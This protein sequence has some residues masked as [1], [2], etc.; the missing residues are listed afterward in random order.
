[1]STHFD[2]RP[3]LSGEYGE[4][5]L[6]G[7]KVTLQMAV[8]TWVLAM[9]LALILVS[10]RLSGN[11]YGRR[12]V[13]VYVAYHRNVPTLVQFLLWYFAIPSLLPD[14][15]Q[16]WLADFGYEFVFAVIA[17][18]LCEAAFFS[19][20]L[21]SGLR[22]VPDGQMEASRS[23]G[24]GYIRSVRYIVMPQ[25][26]RNCLPSLVNHSVT[27]FKNTSLAMAIGLSEL[28][29]ATR[30]VENYT[31]RTFEVYLVATVTYLVISLA[32]MGAGAL[33]A[34]RY[35]IEKAR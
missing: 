29:Y 24:M 23:L 34:R 18:S 14:S 26:I 4:H 11:V 35:R 7:L 1:M 30:E 17:L 19:E 32:L 10:I 21:R 6:E 22:A 5:I 3:I 13:A 31:Y 25:A 9:L 2:L 12:F 16:A 33:L 27:L 20:D 8:I 28:T 15:M